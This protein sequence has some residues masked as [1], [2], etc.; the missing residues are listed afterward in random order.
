M[1]IS[2]L[3]DIPLQNY[4]M[5]VTYEGERASVTYW[6]GECCLCRTRHAFKR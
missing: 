4:L 1:P 3:A 5:H 2:F 6:P